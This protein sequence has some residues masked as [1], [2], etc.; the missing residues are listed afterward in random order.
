MEVNAPFYVMNCGEKLVPAKFLVGPDGQYVR[1]PN[2]S[3]NTIHPL[4]NHY[5]NRDGSEI[6]NCNPDTYLVVPYNYTLGR[7]V[8]FADDVN[9]APCTIFLPRHDDCGI[10]RDQVLRI[11]RRPIENLDGSA[12]RDGIHVPMFQDAASFH[13]DSSPISPGTAQ[14]CAQI[15]GSAY[16]LLAQ[17]INW[18]KGKIT[19]GQA[20][21]NNARNMNSIAAGVGYAGGYVPGP[22]P[23]NPRWTLDQGYAGQPQTPTDQNVLNSFISPNSGALLRSDARDFAAFLPARADW[24]ESNS[25]RAKVQAT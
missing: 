4:D 16:D 9:D 18:V 10:R 5:F 15:G 12:T 8:R 6:R 17:G 21:D 1:N 7:A 2:A 3:P 24:P 23:S 19:L 22:N 13:S 20:W 14:L 11:C 25:M